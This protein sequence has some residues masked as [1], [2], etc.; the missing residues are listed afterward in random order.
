MKN[1]N[2]RHFLSSVAKAAAAIP[3]TGCAGELA[4]S[5]PFTSKRP[6]IIFLLTDDQRWDTMGCAGNKIIHTPN[7]DSLAAEGVRFTNAF[8]TTSICTASRASIFNGTYQ[9]IHR[10]NFQ[11][12]PLSAEMTDISYPCL[13]KAAGYRTG[14]TGKLGVTVETGETARMFDY[15]EELVCP[16]RKEQPDGSDRHLT[17]IMGDKAIEF[18][19]TCT[20]AQPFCLSVSFQAPHAEDDNPDQYV[21]PKEC[22]HLYRNVTI[23]PAANSSPEFF[24]AM[25]KFL[26]E[27]LN[28][29][30]WYWRFDAPQK[31][32]EMTKGYYRMIS[33]VDAVIGRIIEEL[34]K[35]QIYDNTVIMLMGDN[36]YFLGERGFAGKWL[37]HE[38]SIRVP[39]IVFDPQAGKKTRGI[40]VSEMALNIDLAPTILELA[41]VKIPPRIQGRSLV[42]LLKGR[43]PKWRTDFLY[44]YLWFK[45]DI[46]KCE[47]VRTERWKYIRY[48]EEKPLYEEL[49][50]L[51]GDP[52]ERVN[53]AKDLNHQETLN[54][55]RKRCNQLIEKAKR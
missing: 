41:K 23:P 22:D 9:R 34:K 21:W 18:L 10:F 51:A 26:K 39:L 35:R 19:D 50:D 52:Q 17:N 48:F 37:M 25:P 6:N 3:L 55:L 44:E 12:P 24:S 43:K 53:L 49:Y 20:P 33:G 2:R 46:P 45:D 27:S 15:F 29:K 1:F 30:R 47:G 32:Q 42:P 14:F 7:M 16:Y 4:L 31:A 8:V 11:T 13:L 36:G 54:C 5:R 40:T 28:R 38:E